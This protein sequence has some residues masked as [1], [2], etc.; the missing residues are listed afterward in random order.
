VIAIIPARKGSKGLPGKNIKDL[1]GKPMIAYSIEEALKS[2]Y[3]T[4][5]VISTDC[6]EIEEVAVKYG[7]KSPFLRPEHLA[8]DNAKAVDN[9]IYVVDRMNKEFGYDVKDFVVLQPTSPLRKLEDID[10]SIELFKGKNA[11]S[12]I[13]Y[14]EELH[15]I[16]WHKY[17]TD[18][19]KFE[20]IFEE[21]LI[22]RQEIKKSYFPNG[23]VFVF[24]YEFIKQRKYFSDNSYAYI[25]P[26]FRSVDVDTIEDFKYIE[27]LM[28]GGYE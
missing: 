24:D 26:R 21:R 7:A 6:K 3:I 13:S 22:N 4:E 18:E 14:T 11:D 1:I 2:K 25:M 12:V 15:P 10:G 17:I 9:Y 23:A 28:K 8:T 27:F 20:N 19:G 5:V 16:E